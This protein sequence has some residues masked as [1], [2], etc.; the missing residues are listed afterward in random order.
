MEHKTDITGIILAGGKS[1]RMGTDKGFLKLDG[2]TF[3][4]HIINAVKPL[5]NDIIIVSNNPEYDR[6][7][8]KRIEDIMMDAGPLA[9]LYSGLYHSKTENNIVLS[10]DVPLINTTVL[11]KL[12]RQAAKDVDIVQ[13]E[14]NNKTMPL[15]ALYKK[16]CMHQCLELL[17]TGERRLR[18]AVS[19][20]KTKT[21][22]L[23]QHLHRYVKN[24][25]TINQL[26]ALK[27]EVKH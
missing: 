5:V 25:N 21:I 2:E 6:F 10:C 22:V 17:E 7:N 19:Q 18:F 14:S 9:G 11:K 1:S 23:D 4:S 20:F 13:I 24:I 8:L 12:S 26:N 3:I 15:I 16:H 27:N